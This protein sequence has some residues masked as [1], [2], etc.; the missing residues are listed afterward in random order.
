MTLGPTPGAAG[1]PSWGNASWGG[2]R[3]VKKLSAT[4]PH[5][6]AHIRSASERRGDNLNDFKDFNLKAKARIWL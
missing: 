6:H 1:G 2:F 5:D 3:G 4:E